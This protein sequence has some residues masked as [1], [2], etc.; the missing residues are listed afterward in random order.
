VYTFLGAPIL[1]SILLA[2]FKR[3]GEGINSILLSFFPFSKLAYQISLTLCV[4]SII[5]GEVNIAPF[6]S[7]NIWMILLW[8]IVSLFIVQLN[9]IFLFKSNKQKEAEEFV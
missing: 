6:L 3:A 7:W 8:L 9:I 1:I 4:A 2:A 5:A